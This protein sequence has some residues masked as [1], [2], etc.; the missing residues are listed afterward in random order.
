MTGI[1]QGALGEG[2]GEA[3]GEAQEERGGRQQER[4][5]LLRVVPQGREG[6]VGEQGGAASALSA[7]SRNRPLRLL[8]ARRNACTGHSNI[9]VWAWF[10]E[11]LQKFSAH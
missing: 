10:G 3:A 5:R 11:V 9:S 7:L 4:P 1:W 6:E 8:K 2:A